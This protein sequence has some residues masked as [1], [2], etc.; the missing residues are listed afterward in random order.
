MILTAWAEGVGSN[1]VG[2]GGMNEI[3]DLLGI[4][5]DFDVLA[6]VSVGYPVDRIGRGKK[7]RKPLTEVAHRE[8]FGQP[9][10]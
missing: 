1:W 4:P 10:S 5:K 6:I 3:R 2:F 7:K 9:F 8:R